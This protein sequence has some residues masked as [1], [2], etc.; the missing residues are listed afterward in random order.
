M[1]ARV[2]QFQIDDTERGIETH[3]ALER[4]LV[5]EMRK[6]AGYEGC[7]LLRSSAGAA[8]LLSLWEDEDAIR[9]SEG[10]TF[11]SEQLDRFSEWLGQEATS[12]VYSVEYADHP[13]E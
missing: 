7:Y 1:F 13:S 2:I 11:Y 10:N 3:Q 12:D 9:R 8:F 5:P 4:F 6:Q